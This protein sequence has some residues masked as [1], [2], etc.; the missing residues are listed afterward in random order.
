ER[1]VR[2]KYNARYQQHG[3]ECREEYRGR[4]PCAG[5]APA[6][7][8][9][10]AEHN[11]D[12]EPAD[13]TGAHKVSPTA[14]SAIAMPGA[15]DTAAAGAS[16]RQERHVSTPR[17]HS[18]SPMTSAGETV[19]LPIHTVVTVTNSATERL[20]EFLGDAESA[21]RGLRRVTYTA[22][23]TTPIRMPRACATL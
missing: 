11:R 8:R 23:G 15:D 3:P 7:G 2:R 17:G 19:P 1:E 14:R 6:Q 4:E 9:D 12:D 16:C 18:E 13:I 22:Y 20:I 21:S 10:H 5:M